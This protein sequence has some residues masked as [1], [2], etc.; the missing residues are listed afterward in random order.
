VAI[1]VTPVD[2]ERIGSKKA[3]MSEFCDIFGLRQK[4]LFL[5]IF[6]AFFGLRQKN[7]FFTLFTHFL[8]FGKKLVFEHF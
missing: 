2:G 4:N 1:N 8:V 5:R 6:Y 7:V 3:T